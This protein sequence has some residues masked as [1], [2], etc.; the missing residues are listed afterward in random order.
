MGSFFKVLGTIALIC[1]GLGLAVSKIALEPAH[2][3]ETLRPAAIVNDEVISV[4][5]VAMRTRLAILSS[6][7]QDTPE[8]RDRV[9]R[10]VLRTLIDERLQLQEA[11]RLD[12]TISDGQIE[13]AFG[14]L[15]ERNN[16]TADQLRQALQQRSILPSILNDQIRAQIAWQT[17]VQ[18]RFRPSVDISPEE[19]DAVV[20]RIVAQDSGQ[21]R[22]VS[23]IY[24]AVENALN[25]EEVRQDAQRLYQQLQAGANFGGLARE[26]SQSATA[27]L[28]GDLGWIEE[29]ELSAELETALSQMSPGDISPPVRTLAGFT[30]M[31]LKDVRQRTETNIDRAQIQR[32]LE[33]QQLSQLVQQ[34]MQDLRRVANVDIRI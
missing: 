30:I 15:A 27:N 11:N 16:M 26:F 13:Q 7:L 28:G 34:S 4:L 9:A 31:N 20:T 12:I 1:C 22:R 21:Q 18:Q 8:A 25:E 2:A 14:Q 32:N 29:G 3:Q 10:Q 24:L 5:D 33:D 17:V 19:I 6:R 23:E